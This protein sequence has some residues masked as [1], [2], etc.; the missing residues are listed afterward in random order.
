V[1]ARDVLAWKQ[2]TDRARLRA[3]AEL[4]A[5]AQELDMGY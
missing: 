1:S 3:L 4:Q 5:Q 2:R